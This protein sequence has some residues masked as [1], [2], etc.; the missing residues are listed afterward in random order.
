MCQKGVKML[1]SKTT[2][3]KW[4]SKIKKRYVDLGYIFT[5][6]GDEFQVNISDLT[7]SSYA[8]V[9]VMCDYCNQEY[10]ISWYRYI[11]G[12]K[13]LVQ[14]DCCN[15][16][17]KYTIVETSMKK[18]GVNS[19]LKLDAIKKQIA[20]T[21]KEK[22][23]VENPFASVIIKSR[24]ADTNIVKYGDKCP[25]N[26]NT[27][28][29]KLMQTCRE[30]YGVDYFIQTQRKYGKDNPLWKGGIHDE[31]WERLTPKYKQWRDSVF[32]RD[33]YTCQCCHK[34]SGKGMSV[35]LNAHHLCNWNDYIDK[36]YEL[37]NGVTL[38]EK[39]H[40]GFHS[41]YGKKNNTLEQYKEYISI[42]GKKVC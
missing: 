31:R 8:K 23:G 25:L 20:Q 26:N 16:C 9:Q 22:Y 18:Y 42:Y 1:L 39:C 14:K 32:Q 12:N 24:I 41:R 33:W 29:E 13:T 37:D 4:N 6:M 2:V 34:K 19:V 28:M 17:K 40:I 3:I 7:Q 5:K 35:V 15:H 27:I 30:K 38:C 21:N 10:E 36:R 11:A